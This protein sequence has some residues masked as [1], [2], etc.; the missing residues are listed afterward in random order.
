LWRAIDPNGDVIDILLQK[1]RNDAAAKRF[2]RQLPKGQQALSNQLV[3]DKLGS[4]R[5]AHRELISTVVHDTTWYSNNRCEASQ[6]ESKERQMKRFRRAATAQRFL[7]LYGRI[8][9]N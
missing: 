3:T 2:L 7:V 4:Y 1:R 9:K 8:Q 6:R 5:V